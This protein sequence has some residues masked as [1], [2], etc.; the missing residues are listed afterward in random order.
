MITEEIA[1]ER[2]RFPETLPYPTRKVDVAGEMIEEYIIPESDRGE[3]LDMLYPFSPVP[4]LDDTFLDLHENRRFLVR[5]FKVIQGIGMPFLMSPYWEH[6][7]GSVI[8]WVSRRSCR[9][10]RVR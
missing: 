9:K 4:S 7:G 10:G 8:D 5:D 3:V 2:P 1:E 6:S